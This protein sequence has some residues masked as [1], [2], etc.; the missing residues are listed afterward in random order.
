MKRK[1]M[2][3]PN[4]ENKH[5]IAL[6]YIDMSKTRTPYTQNHSKV[7]YLYIMD[8]QYSLKLTFVVIFFVMASG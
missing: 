4:K 8:K 2:H 6:T 5:Y 1:G 7:F 3:L